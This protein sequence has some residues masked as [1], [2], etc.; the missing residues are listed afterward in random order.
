MSLFTYDSTDYVSLM[1][2][3]AD[4]SNDVICG[5]YTAETETDEDG[6]DWTMMSF[7]DVY[8]GNS[9]K[10]GCAEPDDGSCYIFDL[11]ANTY[12]AKYLTADETITYM[13]AAVA[14]AAETE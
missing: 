4:G 2:F 5:A 3:E 8:T 12:E 7:E 1:I 14:V 6:I 13:G 9:C 11:N 10:V